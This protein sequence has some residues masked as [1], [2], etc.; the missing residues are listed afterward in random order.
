V[1]ALVAAIAITACGKPVSST[2]GFDP[3]ASLDIASDDVELAVGSAKFGATITHPTRAARYPAMVVI[4][5]SGPTDRDWNN[6]LITS[7]NGSGKLL[8]DALARRGAVV[9]RF[10]K[11]GTGNNSTPIGD[12]TLDSYR[13]EASAGLAALRARAD[14]DPK[15]LF[16]AGH[17]E[18]GIHAIRTA[19]AEGDRIAGLVL[20]ST[21]GSSMGDLIYV[22]VEKQMRAAAPQIAD[23]ELAT[24]KHALDDI[25]AGREVDPTKASTLPPLQQLVAQIASPAN[26]KLAT[27]LIALDPSTLVGKVTVPVF[28]YNGKKDIQV[29]PDADAAKLARALEAAHR[30]VT[31]F[32]AADADHVLKH[33]DRPLEKI[34]AE[35][36]T[37]PP[38]YNSPTR[39]LDDATVAAIVGW[40][41]RVVR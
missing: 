23:A 18:G 25:A 5:G 31:L 35:L 38:D 4:A 12:I 16:V 34:R 20:L 32:L 8:G 39:V 3:A 37:A 6:P 7:R 24:F 17:S 28:V 15:R 26:R 33:E 29:D 2:S 41:A 14:V 19:L 22:Q 21:P 13:D 30:D 1:R 9:L 40:I 10:D 27:A 11:P 36:A